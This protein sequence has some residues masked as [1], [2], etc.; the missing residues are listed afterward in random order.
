MRLAVTGLWETRDGQG[1]GGREPFVTR[2]ETEVSNP[3]T[4]NY[5]VN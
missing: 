3:P 1:G 2:K 4:K 5:F